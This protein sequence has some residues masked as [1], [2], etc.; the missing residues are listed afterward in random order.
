V[1]DR[2]G[3]QEKKAEGFGRSPINVV[4]ASKPDSSLRV[5][6]VQNDMIIQC[7][8][9]AFI[10]LDFFHKSVCVIPAKAGILFFSSK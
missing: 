7:A 8:I 10:A 1:K 5:G 3:R 2:A 9:Y 4:A 6:F